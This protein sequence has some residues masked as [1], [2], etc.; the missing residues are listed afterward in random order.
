MDLLL[1]YIQNGGGWGRCSESV[2]SS[3]PRPGAESRMF[4]NLGMKRASARLGRINALMEV[5]QVVELRFGSIP[6]GV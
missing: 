4:P 1:L 3:K 6:F 2:K 5:F